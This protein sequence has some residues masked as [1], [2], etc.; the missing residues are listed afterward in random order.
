MDIQQGKRT[1]DTAKSH[2][3]PSKTSDSTMYDLEKPIQMK[4]KKLN[5]NNFRRIFQAHKEDMKFFQKK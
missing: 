1:L 3:I 4:K 2:T 5:E